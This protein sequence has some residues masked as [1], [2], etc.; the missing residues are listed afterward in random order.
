MGWSL[1]ELGD[2]AGALAHFERALA[3]RI[4]QGT[5]GKGRGL[6]LTARWCI[7]RAHRALGRLDEALTEQRDLL[8]EH[9]RAGSTD[10]FVHE[11]IAECLLALGRGIEARPHFAAAYELLS[12]DPW[13]AERVAERIARLR[14]L[15]Q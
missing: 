8:A 10:G 13:P 12:Q 3:A 14:K 6:W 5:D 9:S 15:S 1:F 11:E 7:A 2:H 4:E